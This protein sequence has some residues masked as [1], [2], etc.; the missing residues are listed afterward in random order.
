MRKTP[1]FTSREMRRVQ[2]GLQRIAE[3]GTNA[4]GAH[5]AESLLTCEAIAR[6]LL[7]QKHGVWQWGLGRAK[8]FRSPYAR[9]AV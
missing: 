8:G 1:E 2:A 9:G 7:N 6:D 5:A 3:L 4:A